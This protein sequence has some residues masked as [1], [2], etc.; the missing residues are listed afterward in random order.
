MKKI[1]LLL[2]L[3]LSNVIALGQAQDP[4]EMFGHKSSVVY[5][6]PMTE[7]LYIKNKDTN[8]N[9]KA[10]AFDIEH[11]SVLMLNNKDIILQKMDIEATQLL[12]WLSTDPHASN[13]PSMSPYNFVGNM[14]TR[15][16]DPDGKDIYILFYTSNNE[17]GD[18]M[19]KASA[20]TRQRDIEKGKGFDPSR[21]KVVVLAVQDLATIQNQ[22]NNV[23]ETMSPKYG[24]TA[25]FGVWSH[26]ALDGPTGTARTSS[27]GVAGKQMSL[28]G[29][30]KINFNWKNNG[31]GATASFYGCR[32][33]TDS[34]EP[35]PNCSMLTQTFHPVKSFAWQAS[36]L[37]NFSNVTVSGQTTR[38]FP[39]Q[40]TNYRLNSENGADNFI[41]SETNGQIIF[42]R[43]Y[44]VGGQKRTED[45]NLNEQNVANTMQ[46]N[47][48]GTTTGISYQPGTTR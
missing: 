38:A 32:T 12:R 24:Q 18:E 47:V 13:Y 42:Q 20:L 28:N 41:N 3:I 31:V 14:P 22:V 8:S 17:R 23:V 33:G 39:S 27:D 16:I 48:N 7:L 44:M 11:N 43:T 34:Y 40:F 37:A 19:F 30:S 6:T 2:L 1:N 45:W 26:G 15:A 21:D 5:E 46:N 4:Y 36:T 35:D 29:W 25:E 10:L 9:I